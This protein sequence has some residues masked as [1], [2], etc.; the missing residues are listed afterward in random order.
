MPAA[1]VLNCH[2]QLPVRRSVWL[3]RQ[4]KASPELKTSKRPKARPALQASSPLT[5]PLARRGTTGSQPGSSRLGN[6][7]CGSDPGHRAASS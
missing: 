7:A 2:G 3:R 4:V 5:E 6:R 1:A